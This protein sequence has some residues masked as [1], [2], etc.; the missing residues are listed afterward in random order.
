MNSDN[1]AEPTPGFLL[2]TV[3][4]LPII[5]VFLAM[6]TLSFLD[7]LSE[8]ITEGGISY[9]FPSIPPHTGEL[10]PDTLIIDIHENGSVSIAD[11]LTESDGDTALP[12]LR[13]YLTA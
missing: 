12:R 5:V 6:L 3:G 7:K 13:Q 10:S 9:E 4:F 11:V 2:Q 8:V 1:N